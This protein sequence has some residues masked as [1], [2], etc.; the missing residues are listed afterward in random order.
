MFGFFKKKYKFK[1]IKNLEEKLEDSPD[2]TKI[3]A[4]IKSR[5]DKLE[6]LLEKEEDIEKATKAL[7]A[8]AHPQ[9]LKNLRLFKDS[10]LT[11]L[12]IIKQLDSEYEKSLEKKPGKNKKKESGFLGIFTLIIILAIVYFW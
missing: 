1:K 12:E 2:D 6:D 7:K 8:M 11:M 5:K 10:D 4:A 9:R 3:Q